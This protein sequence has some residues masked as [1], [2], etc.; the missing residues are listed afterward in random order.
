MVLSSIGACSAILLLPR[1]VSWVPLEAAIIL[2]LLVGVAGLFLVSHLFSRQLR[3]AVLCY[4][5]QVLVSSLI[6]A[7]ILVLAGGTIDS[8][9]L[10]IGV[11]S[12]FTIAWL[13]GLVTPGA[14]AGLGAREAALVLLLAGLAPESTILVAAVIGR[15]V[16]TLGDLL[17]FHVGRKY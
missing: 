8:I 12:S 6:F 10:F 11:A 5:G 9:A 1:I 4:A 2:F 16:S 7:G 17:F 3:N 14:P 15:L 13:I